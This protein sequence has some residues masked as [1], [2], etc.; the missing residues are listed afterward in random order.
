[1]K[2]HPVE[3]E[4]FYLDRHRDMTKLT[5]DSRNFAHA[6]KKVKGNANIVGIYCCYS[7]ILIIWLFSQH[8]VVTDILLSI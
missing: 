7:I 8:S 5:A 6:A 4:L 3:A 2:I 1:M